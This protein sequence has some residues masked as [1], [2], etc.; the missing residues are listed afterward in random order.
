MAFS[1]RWKGPEIVSEGLV[2]Y[3]DAGSPNSYY[4]TTA[5]NTWKDI[6][7]QNYSA[8]MHNTTFSSANGGSF[9]FDGTAT[10]SINPT[11]FTNLPTG[12][13]ARTLQAWVKSTNT[14]QQYQWV[15][16]Y[17]D[18]GGG[19]IP[20]YNAYFMGI[21]S[22]PGVFGGS[23][24]AGPYDSGFFIGYENDWVLMTLSYDGTTIRLYRNDTERASSNQNLT[25][26][27][28][29]ILIGTQVSPY[30]T[31][32]EKWHGNIKNIMLYN[33]ALSL[34]DISKNYNVTKTYYGL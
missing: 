2:M 26:S 1:Y 19:G 8:S 10:G 30:G 5:G 31:G 32:S 14:S 11:H 20:S 29:E 7:D 33:K 12:S 21:S 23:I 4:P 13:S 22:H 16:A 3:L 17:G 15:F 25:T 6:S 28:S 24:F 34:L 18:Y 27:N 9:V